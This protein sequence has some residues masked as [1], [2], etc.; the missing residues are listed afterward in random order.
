M[1]LLLEYYLA[2]WTGPL[3]ILWD[4]VQSR[5][6]ELKILINKYE[7]IIAYQKQMTA[8]I[9]TRLS[10]LYQELNKLLNIIGIRFL[11]IVHHL[12][13]A[14]GILGW[15]SGSLYFFSVFYFFCAS[16]VSAN[17]MLKECYLIINCDARISNGNGLSGA[18]SFAL[19]SFTVRQ[20]E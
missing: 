8:P 18:Q 14:Y 1:F 10:R 15:N 6:E 19:P 4:T 2:T 13:L 17:I 9:L 7:K 3:G 5:T 16:R 20:E 11:W 12:Q